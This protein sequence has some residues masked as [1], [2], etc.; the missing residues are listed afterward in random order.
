MV[1]G[2]CQRV[3]FSIFGDCLIT[4]YKILLLC[5]FAV[6]ATA[7]KAQTADSVRNRKVEDTSNDKIF[8]AVE[9]EPDFPGGWTAYRV[10]L[11]TN[12][13][14][15]EKARTDKVKGKVIV[16]FVVEKDGSLSDIKIYKGLSKETDAE[17]IRVFQ[18]SPKWVAGTQNG[19]PVR[20][21]YS[22]PVT[23]PPE[24]LIVPKE[25][26][27]S[28]IKMKGAEETMVTSKDLAD[29]YR[30]VSPPD[31][32]IDKNLAIVTDYYK[33][34]RPKMIGNA[35]IIDHQLLLTGPSIEYYENGKRKSIKKYI[36]GMQTGE[37]SQYYPNGQ[38]YISAEYNAKGRKIIK[39]VR[40]STG[41]II[42]SDGTGYMVMYTTDFKRV[43]EEGPI[44]KGVEEGEW[45][46]ISDD[47]AR[48][49]LYYIGG[50][51]RNGKTYDKNGSEYP[52]NVA[53]KVPAFRKGLGD[54]YKF[55]NK[56]IT[57]PE[58]AKDA[59][60]QG[61]VFVTFI[62]ER[63]GELS[64]VHIARGVGGS[65]DEEAVRAIKLSSKWNPGTQG[66]IPVRMQYT[67]PINFHLLHW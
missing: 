53:F 31:T 14:Y 59:N 67:L 22:L 13:I 7:V 54:F 46:G 66:G 32:T 30:I 8:T 16:N 5:F 63:D 47:S 36:D 33:N 25:T 4:M 48:S 12:L 52:A 11:A 9:N 19:K 10:F 15:P 24:V 50:I 34:G 43:I 58:V 51:F 60:V 17:A 26:S 55:L 21:A 28:Y 29:Y 2:F 65:L 38:L 49:T 3:K 1:T 57:Y 23:F 56:T 44:K 61:K 39:E 20:V 37:F 64:D 27:I 18:S 40:D 6:V 35:I 45:R 42:A 41:K 62:V